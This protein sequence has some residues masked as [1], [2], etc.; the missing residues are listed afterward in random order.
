MTKPW[1]ID[2]GGEAELIPL[3]QARGSYPGRSQKIDY[4]ASDRG[5][6]VAESIKFYL[7]FFG[8]DR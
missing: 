7:L 8:L 4:I 1:G 5:V 3:G 6:F 2:L